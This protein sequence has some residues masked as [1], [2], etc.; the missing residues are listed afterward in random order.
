MQNRNLAIQLSPKA[1]ANI[2]ETVRIKDPRSPPNPAAESWLTEPRHSTPAKTNPAEIF[3]KRHLTLSYTWTYKDF[4]KFV[5]SKIERQNLAER[6]SEPVRNSFDQRRR[7]G[8]NPGCGVA[9]HRAPPPR[10]RKREPTQNYPNQRAANPTESPL[11]RA[12]SA[13]L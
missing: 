6:E 13:Q 10:F 2:R 9:G 5:K 11:A 7:S 12:V 4:T 3:H 8:P 1:K